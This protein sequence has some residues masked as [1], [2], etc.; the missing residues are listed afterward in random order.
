MAVWPVSLPQTPFLGLRD[1]RQDA[2]LRTEMDVGPA[3][4]RRRHT[5]AV[6]NITATTLLTGTQRATFDTFYKTT[7]SEGAL[8]FDWVD[9]VDGTTTSFRFVSPPPFEVVKGGTTA[10]RLWRLTMN[11]EI[12]P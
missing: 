2:R 11:L 4:M 3:K 8:A 12:L 9:P 5:A 1:Q 10:T 7:L 6:R